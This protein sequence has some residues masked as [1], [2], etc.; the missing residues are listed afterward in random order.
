MS[1]SMLAVWSVGA[2][3]LL[4]SSLALAQPAGGPAPAAEAPVPAEIAGLP[5]IPGLPDPLVFNDGRRVTTAAQWRQRREEIKALFEQN[6]YGH[7]P[8][9]PGNVEGELLSSTPILDGIATHR[10]IQLRFG[11]EKKLSI[12]LSMIVPDD[13]SRVSPKPVVLWLFRGNKLPEGDL[14]PDYDLLVQRGY[15]AACFAN[16]DCDPDDADRTNGYHPFYP[17]YDWATLAVWA[18]GMQRAVDWLVTQDFVAGDKIAVS[19]HSRRG[20][21]ALL[22]AAFDERIA[23]A[24]PSGSGCGGVGLSRVAQVTPEAETIAEI[25]RRFPY[26]FVPRFAQFAQ[27]VERLP[28]DQHMLIALMAPR[29]VIN[30]D[31]L[32]DLWANPRGE[33]DGMLAALPV[34]RLLKAGGLGDAVGLRFREGGHTIT[35]EDWG[36]ILDFCD[37]AMLR[38][39]VDRRFDESPF[40]PR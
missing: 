31:G 18:W 4:S 6:V 25:T 38:K 9:A 37:K 15:I 19:G 16:A 12:R 40:P 2:V 39:K 17:D 10:I 34:Y 36:A 23:L 27:H 30:N 13:A 20:K 35:R 29:A 1:G 21:A 14:W 32:A 33:H 7:M 11:P 26:W 22:A 28:V 3:L 5:V 24:A 8:P